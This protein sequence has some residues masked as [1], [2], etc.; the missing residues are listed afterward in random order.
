MDEFWPKLF[1]R[2]DLRY[3]LELADNC[4]FSNDQDSFECN[5]NLL[6]NL[7][8]FDSVVSMCVNPFTL[9][10]SL[11]TRLRI[12][13]YSRLQDF[14]THPLRDRYFKIEVS[15]K[16]FLGS[17]GLENDFASLERY[18]AGGLAFA[19]PNSWTE[20]PDSG[21]IYGTYE[22]RCNRWILFIFA[23]QEAIIETRVRSIIE[24]T[25][26]HL[27]QAFKRL[28]SICTAWKSHL[29]KRECE[30][31]NWL[32]AGKTSWEIAQILGISERCVNFHVEN[33][34]I[35]LDSANRTQAV[36]IAVTRGLIPI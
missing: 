10:R 33:I 23:T 27:S 4:L 2:R 36:A 7:T 6:K 26:P 15:L 30:V 17:L 24:L 20:S 25:L 9:P 22:K 5:L 12:L 19:V 8:S 32:K 3:I 1:T 11:K 14:S 29:T 21:L 18:T 16:M 35:K 31:L 13:N 34:K 28:R